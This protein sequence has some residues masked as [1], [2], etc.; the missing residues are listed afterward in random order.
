MST[1]DTA[2]KDGTSI[3]GWNENYGWRET[4]WTLYGEGS[5]AYADHKAGNGPDGYWNWSEP[6]NN[7]GAS[8][9]PTR[10]APLPGSEPK[11]VELAVYFDCMP[12]SNGQRNWTVM[13]YRKGGSV[14]DGLSFVRSEYYD[15][16]RYE[17]DCLRFLIGELAEEPDILAYDD[18][19]TEPPAK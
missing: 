1:I 7:W 5:V 9:R 11:P 2:P 18:K 8:W 19:I 4:R 3:L 15:R 10:W 17:A 12:E 6:Q 13:L 16:A 14:F